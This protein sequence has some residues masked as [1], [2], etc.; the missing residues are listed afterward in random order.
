MPD[1]Q[2][3]TRR[4]GFATTHWSIVLQATR[5]GEQSSQALASLCETY[6]YPV[7][8]FI[9]RQGCAAEEARDLTQEFFVRV[10]ERNSLHTADPLRGRFRAFL[11]ASVRHFLANTRR[12]DRALKRGGGQRPLTFELD[13]AEGRYQI[14]D[15]HQLTPEKLF[16]RRWAL[17]LLD[18]A[19]AR[20][21][22][23]HIASGRSETFDRLNQYLTGDGVGQPYAEMARTLGVTEGS[24]KVSIHRLRR[25]FREA[26]IAEIS[27]TVADPDD[28]EAEIQH[29]LDAIC[30]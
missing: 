20:V 19:L 7:Y 8:A 11:L 12:T 16:D 4:N 26:L 27:E 28:V 23:K 22:D 30:S 14:E 29:L 21:R 2:R 17:L 1:S 9:R 25:Q 18:R 15:G 3:F 24:V 10:L 6:W 5:A 13:G